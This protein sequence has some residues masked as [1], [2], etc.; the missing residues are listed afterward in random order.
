MGL[1]L[2]PSLRSVAGLAQ[3]ESGLT[4]MPQLV[5]PAVDIPGSGFSLE[6]DLSGACICVCTYTCI[7]IYI[8]TVHNNTVISFFILF[9]SST[10]IYTPYGQRFLTNLFQKN[11]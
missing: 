6:R 9:V 3:V 8:D 7:H 2:G 5:E 4:G 10:K 11:V 1:S